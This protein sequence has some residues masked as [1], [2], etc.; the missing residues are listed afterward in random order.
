MAPNSRYLKPASDERLSLI[1]KPARMYS[2]MEVVSI[3]RYSITRSAAEAMKH[4]PMV[5]MIISR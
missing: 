5:E 1:M 2:G 4:I 3:D